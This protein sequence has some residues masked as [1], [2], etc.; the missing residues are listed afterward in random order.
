[1]KH[2]RANL[3]STDPIVVSNE[4]ICYSQNPD[5]TVRAAGAQTQHPNPMTRFTVAD[6][7]RMGSE[8]GFRYRLPQ[9]SGTRDAIDDVCVAEGRVQ[10][11]SIRPGLTLVL[12]DIIAHHHYE[13]TS[14][15]HPQFSTIVMLQG[16][17]QA[18]LDKH[19]DVRMVAQSG[20]S[21]VYGDAVSMTG[22]HPAGQRMR[23]VNV[24]LSDPAGAGDPQLSEMIAQALRSPGLR[25]RRWPVQTHMIQAIEQLLDSTW[26]GSLHGLLRDGVSMQLLAHALADFSQAPAQET[27]TSARDRQLLE[28]VRERL[29][30]APG[31]DHTLEDLARLACMSPSTLRAKFQAT[32]H[33]SVFT[34]LR[35]R[36]LEVAREQLA[37]GWSVQQ[38][39]HF[40]GYRHATNFATAFRERYGIAPSELS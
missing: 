4:N 5:R 24:S 17:A 11:F 12:S 8:A 38:A 23:S 22:V 35:E 25:L 15:M 13:A 26:Q 14:V 32:Y 40:V 6:F 9:L 33:R 21:A 28:R 19:D 1:M 16:Q 29:Y 39:A 30:H 2:P 10:E 31:E 27:Q 7:N 34:W 20:L 18:L 36:R 37:Q 3:P